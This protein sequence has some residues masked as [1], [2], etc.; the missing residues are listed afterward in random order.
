MC[1]L[2]ARQVRLATPTQRQSL[3]HKQLID[4]SS[5]SA[6]QTD[7]WSFIASDSHCHESKSCLTQHRQRC[8]FVPLNKVGTFTVEAAGLSVCY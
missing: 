5:P 3:I 7:C 4:E 1:Q 2:T 6:S 8:H